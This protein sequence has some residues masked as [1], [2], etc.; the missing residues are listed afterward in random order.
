MAYGMVLGQTPKTAEVKF[1][2]ESIPVKD[3]SLQKI[4][5]NKDIDF[6]YLQCDNF[7]SDSE[8]TFYW[9]DDYDSSKNQ[10]NLYYIRIIQ[11]SNGVF[12]IGEVQTVIVKNV[13]YSSY[14]S[15]DYYFR[16]NK[17]YCCIS[18]NGNVPDFEVWFGNLNGDTISLQK[19]T[20]ITGNRRDK[21]YTYI[22]YQGIV[23]IQDRQDISQKINYFDFASS[24][25]KQFPSLPN[26][27]ID[28][29]NFYV[30]SD[31][32]GILLML[33]I[34]TAEPLTY[35]IKNNGTYESIIP[36]GDNFPKF[37]RVDKTNYFPDGKIKIPMY[38]NVNDKDI[39]DIFVYDSV[40]GNKKFVN[41]NNEMFI[42]SY[43][44][45]K[46]YLLSNY[47]FHSSQEQ[48][49][50]YY[51][52]YL[53]DIKNEIVLIDEYFKDSPIAYHNPVSLVAPLSKMDSKGF[54]FYYSPTQK[55]FNNLLINNKA[56]FE[57]KSGINVSKSDTVNKVVIDSHFVNGSPSYNW[58]IV[59]SQSNLT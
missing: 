2:E 38:H 34:E 40:T 58:Y 8:M 1:V 5:L 15:N 30:M 59:L 44:F 26:A 18:A 24:S 31:K 54:C 23:F 51:I 7:S 20:S 35:Y 50:N 6:N 4:N 48:Y 46:G 36:R 39:V 29:N 42:S 11:L 13:P 57:V 3:L 45:G 9:T 28:P 55:S 14:Y 12:N 37:V 52:G 25:I 47:V 41:F 33:N 22:T 53:D 27:T 21:F 10:I 32:N 56:M 16:N 19:Q 17:L 43:M 49:T